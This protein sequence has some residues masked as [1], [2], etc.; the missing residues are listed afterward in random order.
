MIPKYDKLQIRDISRKAY[1]DV[2]RPA[3]MPLAAS[4]LSPRA[5]ALVFA[6]R[7]PLC[8][9]SAAAISEFIYCFVI[10]MAA[11]VEHES[12]EAA[13]NDQGEERS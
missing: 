12:H 6:L 11:A 8:L 1:V 13:A 2:L 10:A 7:H 9:F 4:R 3:D 5:E